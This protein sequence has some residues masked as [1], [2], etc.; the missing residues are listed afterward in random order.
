MDA[1]GPSAPTPAAS[2]LAHGQ[3]MAPLAQ[4]SLLRVRPL[5]PKCVGRSRLSCCA[6]SFMIDDRLRR[7][8]IWPSNRPPTPARTAHEQWSWVAWYFCSFFFL[9]ELDLCVCVCVQHG[10]RCRPGPWKKRRLRLQQRNRTPRHTRPAG[11][12]HRCRDTVGSSSLTH[13]R[14]LPSRACRHSNGASRSDG[15]LV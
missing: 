2:R 8:E 1:L 12:T 7:G 3:W 10:T 6:V 13:S 9:F 11:F 15:G 5:V 14:A 4:R